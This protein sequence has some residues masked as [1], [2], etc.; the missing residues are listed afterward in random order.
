[1]KQKNYLVGL[2]F[3]L[4]SFAFVTVVKATNQWEPMVEI[5]GIPTTGINLST[6]LVGLNFVMVRR[7]IVQICVIIK[8][9]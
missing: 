2:F 7:L 9:M 3:T 5:P 8:Q 1:M 6:Y 4:S